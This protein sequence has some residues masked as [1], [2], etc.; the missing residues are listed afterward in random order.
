MIDALAK[1]ISTYASDVPN[2]LDSS[3]PKNVAEW[4]DDRVPN[5]ELPGIQGTGLTFTFNK[6]SFQ[7]EL[8]AINTST[9][10]DGVVAL[11]DA[12]ATAIG[13]SVADVAVGSSVGA[14]SPA[15]TWSVV[16]S[17]VIDGAS[18]TAGRDKL[19]E[20]ENSPIAG[21]PEE[22]EFPVKLREAF[23]LLTITTTGMDSTPPSSGGPFPLVD[24]A[25]AVA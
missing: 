20:L 9:L 8:E 7:T 3:G 4:T 25:R 23:L 2:V 22:S 5:M 10:H 19:L 12:W 21:T 18:V 1:W 6:G 16:G 15:T 13:G 17:T 11:A 14:P 24:S